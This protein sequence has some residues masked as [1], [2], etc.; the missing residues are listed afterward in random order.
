[1]KRVRLLLVSAAL[2]VGTAYAIPALRRLPYSSARD[3]VTDG[4]AMPGGLLASIFYPEGVH[5]GGGAATWAA[6]AIVGN[7]FFYILVWILLLLL[8]ERIRQ[9]R[10]YN[11]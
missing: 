7:L 8:W 10:T 2:G 4:L 3:L 1:M 11:R 6:V 5:T 9:G